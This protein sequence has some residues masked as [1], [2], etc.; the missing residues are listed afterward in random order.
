MLATPS[1]SNHAVEARPPSRLQRQAHPGGVRATAAP[2]DGTAGSPAAPARTKRTRHRLP[3]RVPLAEIGKQ[4]VTIPVWSM[5]EST[6]VI[7][8]FQPAG[9]DKQGQ[10]SPDPPMRNRCLGANATINGAAPAERRF[11][12]RQCK[13]PTPVAVRRQHFSS[14]E[15]VGISPLDLGWSRTSASVGPPIG[16]A[17]GTTRLRG[18]QT[19]SPGNSAGAC[20][21]GGSEPG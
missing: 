2:A 17:A 1:W 15:T 21:C 4:I 3:Q 6:G 14:H 5:R 18:R 12:H 8:A 11:R 16:A 9:L 10:R 13:S 20:C 7:E 19:G